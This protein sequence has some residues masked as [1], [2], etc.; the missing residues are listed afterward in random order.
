MMFKC[1]VWVWKISFNPADKS[2]FRVL[3]KWNSV[4]ILILVSFTFDSGLVNKIP[5][6][7]KILSYRSCGLVDFPQKAVCT[8]PFPS[9]CPHPSPLPQSP[10]PLPPVSFSFVLQALPVDVVLTLSVPSHSVQ[11]LLLGLL[12]G[13]DGD[14]DWNHLQ[15]YKVNNYRLLWHAH[16]RCFC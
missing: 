11:T 15:V 16:N 3:F 6:P 9:W 7:V 5:G 10:S 4:L 13:P 8:N 14:M 2:A 1:W 12:E